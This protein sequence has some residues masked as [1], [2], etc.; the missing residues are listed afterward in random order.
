MLL[1][2][3]SVSQVWVLGFQAW[4]FPSELVLCVFYGGKGHVGHVKGSVWIITL[5]SK[6]LTALV[7]S[8]PGN[9]RMEV[10]SSSLDFGSHGQH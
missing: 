3:C 8:T 9:I 6:L 4:N 5:K 10:F 7:I 1:E 2:T